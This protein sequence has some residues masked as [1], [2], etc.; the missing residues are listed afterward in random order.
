M[1]GEE[2]LKALMVLGLD[3]DAVAQN[4][5]LRSL[6]PLL[7]NFYR[8]RLTGAADDVE[9][10]VQETL[11]SIHTRRESYDRERPFTPWLFAIAR[12]RLIDHHRRTRI[13]VPIQDV[14]SILAVEGFEA[15]ASARLDIDSL[16]ATISSKQA[17]AIRDTHIEG[18]SVAEAA[19]A[20]SIGESDVKISVHRGLKA[21][22]ARMRGG[23]T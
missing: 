21:L 10:L 17:R 1:D 11:I 8:R 5:L 22:A 7:R 4:A 20:A 2:H 15:A 3:G 6:V 14:E 16:L 12:Y 23:D 19:R 18:L 9:D 13:C